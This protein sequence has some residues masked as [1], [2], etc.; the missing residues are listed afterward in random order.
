MGLALCLVILLSVQLASCTHHHTKTEAKSYPANVTPL[1][2]RLPDWWTASWTIISNITQEPPYSPYGYP[3]SVNQT[4]YYG[5]GYALYD[6]SQKLYIEV[7]NDYCIPIWEDFQ[8]PTL[9]FFPCTF[10]N[11]YDHR[12]YVLTNDATRPKG[13]PGPCC[14]FGNPFYPPSPDF[15]QL[16]MPYEKQSNIN[17]TATY[18]YGVNTGA[19]G[20]GIFRFEIYNN[21]GRSPASFSFPGIP[22]PTGKDTWVIQVYNDFRAWDKPSSDVWTIPE[23]CL[24]APNCP[25][26]AVLDDTLVPFHNGNEQCVNCKRM[27]EKHHY[28]MLL[29]KHKKAEL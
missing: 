20:G 7:Y 1:A 21:D 3:S 16:W 23:S 9:G 28:S 29:N 15:P 14:L 2:P 6:W 4:L 11:S 10:L 17:G 22:T 27:S 25:S 18:V 12:S 5:T 8:M 26:P 19:V 24:K 13:W